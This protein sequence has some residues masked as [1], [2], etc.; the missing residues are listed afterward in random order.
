MRLL[1][2]SGHCFLDLKNDEGNE[3]Q[4]DVVC[5]VKRPLLSA[6]RCLRVG[7]G[8]RFCEPFSLNLTFLG[9]RFEDGWFWSICLTF[10]SSKEI[11]TRVVLFYMAFSKWSVGVI[12]NLIGLSP[13]ASVSTMEFGFR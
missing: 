13:R 6:M 1:L 5:G 4:M 10:M 11:G 3:L 7:D 9:F 12:C 8:V 2:L